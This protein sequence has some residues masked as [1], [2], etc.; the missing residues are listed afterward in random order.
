[1][2]AWG[3]NEEFVQSHT[4]QGDWNA[5]ILI[6][7]PD[8]WFLTVLFLSGASEEHPACVGPSPMTMLPKGFWGRGVK[9]SN[10]KLYRGYGH[11]RMGQTQGPECLGES[12]SH[13]RSHLAPLSQVV[14]IGTH[15]SEGGMTR[16]PTHGEQVPEIWQKEQAQES[17]VHLASLREAA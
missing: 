2:E 14:L 17:F 10:G 6:P 12:R 4:A 8:T 3:W 5:G 1:M 15:R 11:N 13:L 7:G 9:V 16:R